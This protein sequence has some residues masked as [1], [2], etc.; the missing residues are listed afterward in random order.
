MRFVSVNLVDVTDIHPVKILAHQKTISENSDLY[1]TCSTYAI[2]KNNTGFV[3]L[4]K[5]NVAKMKKQLHQDQTDATFTIKVSLNQSGNYSCVFSTR[6][7]PVDIVTERGTTI[8]R[9]TIQILV[10][11]TNFILQLKYF[12]KP[13]THT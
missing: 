12:V 5:D 13:H 8:R 4:C 7:Y 9:I 1:V 11:G 2:K 10:I 6:D 3:Y